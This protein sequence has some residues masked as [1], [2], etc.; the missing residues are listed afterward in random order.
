LPLSIS[1]SN[2]LMLIL[3]LSF[4]FCFNI[5]LKSKKS[6]S[7][8]KKSERKSYFFVIKLV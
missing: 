4:D 3:K 6:N 2:F 1:F 8:V 7:F 5:L